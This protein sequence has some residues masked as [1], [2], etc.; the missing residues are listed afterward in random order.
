MRRQN[1]LGAVLALHLQKKVRIPSK[2]EGACV[3][4]ANNVAIVSPS[5]FLFPNAAPPRLFVG[6]N[7]MK[8]NMRL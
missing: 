3:A 8:A 1:S 2:T 5:E 7:T 6:F 4:A